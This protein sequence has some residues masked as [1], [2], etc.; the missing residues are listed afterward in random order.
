MFYEEKTSRKARATKDIDMI[1]IVE[2]MSTDY[3]KTLWKFIK[4]GKYSNNMSGVNKNK[5]QFFRFSS[6]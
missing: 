1:V 3:A 6:P 2:N 5:C 4:D